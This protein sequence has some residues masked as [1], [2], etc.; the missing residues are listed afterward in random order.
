MMYL[1]F[2]IVILI[3]FCLTWLVRNI[4]IRHSII[5]LPND[6]SSHAIP[7]PRGGGLAIS[8]TWFAGLIYLFLA[9][10]VEL[11]LFY[12][13][14]S[15]IPLTLIGFIDDVVNLKPYV[16][17]LVQF[18]CAGLA[19]FF[20]GGLQS[21]TIANSNL[22]FFWVLTSLAFIAI[23]WSVNLFNFLDGIDGYIST[24]IIFIGASLYIFTGDLLGLL[25][26]FCSWLF[27]LELATCQNI[28]GGCW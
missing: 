25:L 23:I 12:A 20:L 27:I 3:S 28:H 14:L 26:C 18:A 19:L 4:A 22:Q 21:I 10:K 5:D 2:I 17:F 13:L 15:G 24:E 11:T 1:L 16:R 9:G 8:I 7:T 6:R